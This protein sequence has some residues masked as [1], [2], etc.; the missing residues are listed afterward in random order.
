MWE[1]VP[2]G[3]CVE[4]WLEFLDALGAEIRKVKEPDWFRIL[5]PTRREF[6]HFQVSDELADNCR[7]I[8]ARLR[9][10]DSVKDHMP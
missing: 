10:M 5:C 8:E 7:A 4:Q 1:G 2:A 3:T 6:Y 9:N